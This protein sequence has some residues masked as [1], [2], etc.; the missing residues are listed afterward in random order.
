MVANCQ[1]FYYVLRGETCNSIAA[2]LRISAQQI[3]ALNPNA[4][5]DCTLLFADYFACV[6]L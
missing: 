3:I 1:T 6:G 4:R 2:K 5:P